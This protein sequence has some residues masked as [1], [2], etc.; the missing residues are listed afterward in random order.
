MKSKLLLLNRFGDH[1]NG[2]NG[3]N[4]AHDIPLKTNLLL[5]FFLPGKV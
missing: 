2:A 4:P 3:F 5:Q 1:V